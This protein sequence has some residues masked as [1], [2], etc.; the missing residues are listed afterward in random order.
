MPTWG[1]KWQ[2]VVICKGANSKAESSWK[3]LP[4]L[5]SQCSR[6]SVIATRRRDVPHAEHRNRR[7]S[8]AQARLSVR[9]NERKKRVRENS[10]KRRGEP[11]QLSHE[12]SRIFFDPLS[13]SP[14]PWR[15]WKRLRGGTR[16]SGLI[17]WFVQSWKGLEFYR[18]VLKSPWIRLRSLKSTWFLY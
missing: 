16:Y 1:G 8:V 5:I 17:P 4:V 13:L 3:Y 14:L 18:V 15:A 10:G 11:S 9:E 2:V 12:S 6:L 7:G